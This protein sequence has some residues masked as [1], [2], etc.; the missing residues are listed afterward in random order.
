VDRKRSPTK[1][2]ETVTLR[3]LLDGLLL[4]ATLCPREGALVAYDGDEGFALEA[5]EALYYEILSAT[6]EEVLGL[7][8]AHYRLLRRAEDFEAVTP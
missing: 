2:W 7:E 6:P 5:L 4:E 8:R 1:G 3:C